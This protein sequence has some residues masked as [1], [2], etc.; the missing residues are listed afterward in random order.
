MRRAG[1]TGVAAVRPRSQ[2]ISVGAARYPTNPFKQPALIFGDTAWSLAVQLDLA[3]TEQYFAIRREQGFNA[4]IVNFIEAAFSD[5]PP[6]NKAGQAPFTGTVSGQ[7]D[8]STPNSAYWDHN[9][10]MV[11]LGLRYGMMPIAFPIYLGSHNGDQGWYQQMLANGQPRVDQYATFIGNTFG[12]YPIMWGIGGDLSPTSAPTPLSGTGL[13]LLNQFGAALRAIDPVHPMFAHWDRNELSSEFGSTLL[14]NTNDAYTGEDTYNLLI[15]NYNLAG[16]ISALLIEARYEGTF[17]GQPTL[18]LARLRQQMYAA[19]ISGSYGFV[20]GDHGVWPFPSGWET[21]LLDPGALQVRYAKQLFGVR[22]QYLLA[23]DQDSDLVTSSR[24]V[25]GSNTYISA[26]KS[27]RF[28]VVYLPAG[29]SVTCALSS[30]M[31]APVNAWW[32]DP[33]SGA[34]TSIVGSPFSGA[35]QSF[36]VPGTNSAGDAD[37]ALVLE[38]I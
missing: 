8:F 32:F 34:R 16:P 36:T 5:D 14:H 26:G 18:T 35:S 25:F 29:G 22:P 7:P 4:Y 27:Q 3:E 2:Q 1:L 12:Q 33:T 15:E 31:D 17:P 10:A 19:Y 11:E 20:Y 9:V 30:Q 37:W 6:N 28:S 21:A 24:G 38:S 13:T 23:P